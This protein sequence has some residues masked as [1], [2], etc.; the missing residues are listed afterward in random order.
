[1]TLRHGDDEGFLRGLFGHVEIAGDA[2]PI[3]AVNGINRG[4]YVR[5]CG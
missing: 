5:E 4:G 3:G 1:M 2:A